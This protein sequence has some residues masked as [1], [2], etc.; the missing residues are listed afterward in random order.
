MCASR[1]R[2]S[3]VKPNNYKCNFLNAN[4]RHF[5]SQ[6]QNEHFCSEKINDFAQHIGVNY[7]ASIVLGYLL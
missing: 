5:C 4:G 2:G 7:G 3:A 1:L 6:I